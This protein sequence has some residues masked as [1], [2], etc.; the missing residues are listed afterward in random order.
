MNTNLPEEPICTVCTLTMVSTGIHKFFYFS[1]INK[2]DPKENK[3]KTIMKIKIIFSDLEA[4][5]FLIILK[6]Q[7]YYQF[8]LICL[9]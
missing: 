1:L 4:L 7:K 5:I 6:I 2:K 9:L 8:L 3:A